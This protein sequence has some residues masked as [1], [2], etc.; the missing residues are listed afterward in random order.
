M[1]N[2]TITI[3]FQEMDAA[4]HV[5]SK[6]DTLVSLILQLPRSALQS[7]ETVLIKLGNFVMTETFHLL[8][9]AKEIVQDQSLDGLAQGEPQ[10]LLKHVRQF[11]ETELESEQSHVITEILSTLMDAQAHVQLKPDGFVMLPVLLFAFL[12]VEMV[13]TLEQR[14]VMT[15]IILLQMDVIRHVPVPLLDTIAPVET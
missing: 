14:S 3:S 4:R 12:F 5:K 8:I 7:V 6:L 10:L 15:V 2:V 9:N 13:L 11:A 1:N